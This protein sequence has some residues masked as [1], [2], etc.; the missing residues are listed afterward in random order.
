MRILY[1]VDSAP[2]YLADQLYV[3]LCRVLGEEQVIDYP[4]KAVYH[5][6]R[7]RL[8]YLPQVK[9]VPHGEEAIMSLLRDG[10]VDLVIVSSPRAAIGPAAEGLRRAVRLPPCILFDGEDDA[11]VRHDIVERFGCALYFKRE[12]RWHLEAGM[13]ER[14]GRWRVFRRNPDLLNRTHPLPFSVVPGAVTLSDDGPRPVDVSYVARASHPKRLQAWRLLQGIRHLRCESA[15]YAEPTDRQSKM[16]SGL[17]RLLTKL[18]GDP[19]VTLE[20]QGRRLSF[21]EYHRLLRRSKMAVSIRG[22]GFDTLRYWE[23]VS[24]KTLLISEQP[25]ICIPHNFEHGTHALFCKPDLSDL[26]KLIRT[27]AEDDSA[28]ATMVTAAYAHLMR[29]HT[30]ERRAE[31]VLDVSRKQV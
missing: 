30:C 27:Y 2:D 21:E 18:F 25:D 13:R 5:D 24:A 6:P 22:G 17:P 1:L 3:G 15:L 14:V 4:W 23:I 10:H 9:G 29:Y 11:E 26:M 31:Y 16:K 19:P 20:Q 7:Q 28:R 12:Y 8:S